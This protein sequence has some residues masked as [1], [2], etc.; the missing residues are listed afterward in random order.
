MITLLKKLNKLLRKYPDIASSSENSSKIEV[1]NPNLEARTKGLVEAKTNTIT[2]IPSKF[3]GAIYPP[4]Y[5]ENIIMNV[6]P[7]DC[8][9]VKKQ[10][11]LPELFSLKLVEA[12]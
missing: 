12:S 11:C 2:S 3:T 6:I 1:V 8:K 7:R 10:N 5:P 9:V 4:V